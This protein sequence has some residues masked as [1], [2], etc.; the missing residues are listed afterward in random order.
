MVTKKFDS[1]LIEN[2]KYFLS[3]IYNNHV[4]NKFHT[5]TNIHW[6][7]G[8]S[9]IIFGLTI[10]YLVSYHSIGL[11]VIA[12]SSFLSL[13][14][15]LY[16]FEP[17]KFGNK[18]YAH[19]KNGYMYYKSFQDMSSMELTKKY[20]SLDSYE[21]IVEQYAIDLKNISDRQLIPK[22]KLLKGAIWTLFYGVLMG[23]ILLV[24]DYLTLF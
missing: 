11:F 3:N 4:R 9:A 22:N 10:Q 5:E 16:A 15:S 18:K 6:I 7:L 1:K 21:K 20:L 17:I 19:I 24:A 14:I 12:I 23:V 13:L 2:H 8:A